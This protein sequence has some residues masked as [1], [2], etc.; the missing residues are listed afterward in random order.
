MRPL[1]AFALG[2]LVGAGAL[3]AVVAWPYVGPV[4]VTWRR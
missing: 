3:V 4:S 2:M 1:L